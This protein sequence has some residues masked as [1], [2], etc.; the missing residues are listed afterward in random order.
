MVGGTQRS[1]LMGRQGRCFRDCGGGGQTGW[2]CLW[3]NRLGLLRARPRRSAGSLCSATHKRCSGR[4]QRPSN[5]VPKLSGFLRP[6]RGPASRARPS[7]R[8]AKA[9]KGSPSQP[10]QAKLR[11]SRPTRRPM[12]NRMAVTA[13]KALFKHNQQAK[14]ELSKLQSNWAQLQDRY[15]RHVAAP[16]TMCRCRRF[17]QLPRRAP[18][19]STLSAFAAGNSMCGRARRSARR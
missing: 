15:D 11:Q 6:Q 1:P 13:R 19:T 7:M 14:G 17:R 3:S 5:R 10:K 8:A 4:T 9:A 16:P 18:T 12:S 2:A